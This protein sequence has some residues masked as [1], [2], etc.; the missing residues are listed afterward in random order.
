MSAVVLT[1]QISVD[2]LISILLGLA[3]IVA[4]VFLIIVLARVATMLKSLSETLKTAEEPLNKVIAQLPE[5]ADN[6]NTLVEEAS[7]T[8]PVML[9]DA[10]SLTSSVSDTVSSVS[11]A[12]GNIAQTVAGFTA[13]KKTMFGIKKDTMD[14]VA[15]VASIVYGI[16]SKIVGKKRR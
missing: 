4:L 14:S 12:A 9:H 13:P 3:G 16:V 2:A 8:V 1:A 10:E 15:D 11:D 6:V 5:I 7:V